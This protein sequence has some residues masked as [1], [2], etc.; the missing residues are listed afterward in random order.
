MN[1]IAFVQGSEGRVT[2]QYDYN[3]NFTYTNIP[4]SRTLYIVPTE[5]RVKRKTQDNY[6]QAAT[7]NQHRA[8]NKHF[9]AQDLQNLYMVLIFYSS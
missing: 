2:K 4:K 3:H 5:L 9:G 6:T 8:H 7:R 1:I